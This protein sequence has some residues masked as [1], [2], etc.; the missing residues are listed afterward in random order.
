MFELI[1]KQDPTQSSSTVNRKI[2]IYIHFFFLP[3]K[4]YGICT[5]S[6]HFNCYSF[7]ISTRDFFRFFIKHAKENKSD[8][9]MHESKIF[10]RN[11]D[12]WSWILL[13]D[14]IPAN[15]I[16]DTSAGAKNVY[17]ILCNWVV[18]LRIAMNNSV[19]FGKFR[20]NNER[21]LSP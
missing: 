20:K 14:F 18:S 6:H 2:N 21:M 13:H 11:N 15:Y 5:I 1:E 19:K 9:T 10:R 16:K 3:T 7:K 4:E 17:C 8:D 12:L